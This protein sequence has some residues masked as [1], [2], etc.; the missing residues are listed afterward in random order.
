[1]HLHV[2]DISIIVAY[3]LSTVLIGYWVSHRASQSMQN[4]FLGGNTMPWY[5]LGISNAS[6]MFDI[7]GT[8]LLVSWMFVYGLKSV[9][10]PW[11]WPT[12]N[13]IF[14][15]VY[16]SA[17]LRRSKVMTGAEWI[18]TRF[19]TGRGAQFSHLIVV[20]YAFVSIIGFFTYAFKGIGKFAQT[21][22]PWNLTANEYALIL[23]GITAI[24]VIKGGMISVVIT[25]V[26]QFFILSIA[27]FAVGII[28]MR[29]VAPEMLHRVVPAGWDNIFFGWHL[30][31]DWAT[32]LPAANAKVAQ[33]GY[34]LFGF[35]VIMLLFKGIPISAAGPAPN[36][37]MQRVLS[38]KDPREA[39]MMSAWVNI[40]LTPPR[41]FLVIGLTVLAAA[42]FGP[43]LRAMGTNM[44]FELVLPYAL[45]RF[46]PVGLLGFLIAGLLAAFMS[47]FAATVNAAPPYF[48]ND[49]Y[50]RFI[51]S[52]ASPKT[53]VRLSYLASFSVIVIGVVLGWNVTSVNEV[54]VWIVSG[55]WGGYTA[56][57]VLKWYWWR[58]N[59]WGY[60]WGMV[61]GIAAAL[62]L[63]AVITQVPL[64]QH[65]LATYSINK[66][67]VIVF[68]VV[69]GISLIG[70]FL[71]TFLTKPEDEVVLKDFYRR[72]RPW[73]FWRPVLKKV[74]AEDPSFKPNKAFLRDMFNIAVGIVWQVSLVALP[75]YIVI[76]EFYRVAIALAVILVTSAILKFTW[77]DHLNEREVETNKAA[78]KDDVAAGR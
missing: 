7:S 48:V 67:V 32:L 72:V 50:K 11:L 4:Y 36:Y 73:G 28:A 5:M 15:M 38:A 14:L 68:P 75:L 23:I 45:G 74:L 41:Y 51:N 31:L 1:M 77:Y 61:T 12:F 18:K 22:L 34:G 62:G 78:A 33:D 29:K 40:V 69:V 52:N 43:N 58:F 60:F 6:G 30:N 13:Q 9:W 71:G 49:I 56:S 53:Y 21:Y 3:L 63:P 2:V 66:E 27:S 76:Q 47:N 17:W 25:E 35:F 19:G 57:N 42:F 44:D 55:L 64:V 39:S 26:V 59:G 46:V 70:C 20:I 24:Y 10:I 37:D 65:L 16:L 8:M 54:V